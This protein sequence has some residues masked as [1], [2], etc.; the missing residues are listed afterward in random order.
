MLARALKIPPLLPLMGVGIVLGA[1]G[2]NVVDASELE[3]GLRGLIGVVVAL[4]IFEGSLLLDREALR[5]EPRAVRGLLTTS[6]AV[7]M[8]L[9]TVASRY[10]LEMSWSSSVVLAAV[11]IVTGPT[12]VQP[13]LK[14][15]RLTPR[16]HTALLSE[17]ILIDPIGVVA[18]VVVLEVVLAYRNTSDMSLGWWV[19]WNYARPFVIGTVV[20]LAA[21]VG[22]TLI[23]RLGTFSGRSGDRAIIALCTAGTFVGIGAAEAITHEG[24][25]V[26]AAVIGLL[27]ARTLGPRLRQLRDV[28]EDVASP[29]IGT[30]FVLLASRFDLRRLGESGWREMAFVVVLV[31]LI[32]PVAVFLG[33]FRTGL[34]KREMAYISLIGPRGVVAVSAATLAGNALGA[35]GAGGVEGVFQAEAATLQA[36]V[37]LVVLVTVTWTSLGA[38]PLAGF[39]KVKGEPPSG[40]LIVGAHLVG[41]TLAARLVELGFSV[42][43]IDSNP[44]RVQAAIGDGHEA[45]EGDATDQSFLEEYALTSS[46]GYVVAMTGNLDVDTVVSRWAAHQLGEGHGWRWPDEA[47]SEQLLDQ[48]TRNQVRTPGERVRRTIMA[49]E[50]LVESGEWRLVAREGQ[51]G[52]PL[53]AVSGLKAG[54]RVPSKSRGWRSIAL[55]PS[56][57]RGGAAS[58]T[59]RSD[60]IP[61]RSALIG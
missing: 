10:L 5:H 16:L 54:P 1:S 56:P 20:G 25:L 58:P 51:E 2:L 11:L 18:T 19:M 46:T 3:G 9:T 30:L 35:S 22:T 15:V 43:L 21:G 50:T 45:M 29:L 36:V 48:E 31:L 33:T 55:E 53:V 4:L 23:G 17:G 6:A 32:R 24:G 42:R 40:V 44:A 28:M 39:L 49:A 61:D 26:A 52:L 57:P 59:S 8:C 12:V 14:R 7:G 34:L 38:G 60:G 37:L 13:I 27:M 47:A 41:R